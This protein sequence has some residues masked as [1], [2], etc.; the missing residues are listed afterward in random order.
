MVTYDDHSNAR[1]GVPQKLTLR[2]CPSEP[3]ILGSYIRTF[4]GHG[5]NVSLTCM[6]CI[7]ERRGHLGLFTP[8]LMRT[9]KYY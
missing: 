3:S 7:Y 2:V 9:T 5:L 8:I 6:V 1:S 4:S